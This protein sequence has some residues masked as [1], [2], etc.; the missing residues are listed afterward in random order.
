MDKQNHGSIPPQQPLALI[1]GQNTKNPHCIYLNAM[2]KTPTTHISQS[3]KETKKNAKRK[4]ILFNILDRK[5]PR[6]HSCFVCE[7]G[8]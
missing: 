2:H 4:C 3:K 6:T 1:H 5:I 8:R 7:Q